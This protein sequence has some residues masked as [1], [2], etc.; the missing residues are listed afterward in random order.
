VVAASPQ[1]KNNDIDN[2]AYRDNNDT[3]Y[4]IVA[5]YTRMNNPTPALAFRFVEEMNRNMVVKY[6]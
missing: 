3:I 4:G 2:N 6:I 1:E 5:R